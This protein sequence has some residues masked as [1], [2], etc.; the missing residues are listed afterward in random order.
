MR[1][2]FSI[3]GLLLA[4]LLICSVIHAQVGSAPGSGRTS[5]VRRTTYG[6]KGGLVGSGDVTVKNGGRFET[7]LESGLSLAAFVDF[8]SVLFRQYF[9]WLAPFIPLAVLD[10][11]HDGPPAGKPTH[12]STEAL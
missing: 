6:F 1:N 7:Q 8:S 5:L 9:T 12:S 2:R 10:L 11:L 4:P 3:Y